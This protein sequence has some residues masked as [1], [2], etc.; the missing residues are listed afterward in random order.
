MTLLTLNSAL[1]SQLAELYNE[2]EGRYQLVAD[3]LH[4]SCTGCPDNC[5][6]SYF[7][8]H[9][10]VEWAYLW[11]GFSSLPPAKQNTI[12]ARAASYVKQ[13]EMMLLRG[14]RPN[15][16]CPLNDQ[17]LCMLYN[18]RYMICRL[19]GVPA[20]LSLPDG[21]NFNFPG[22]FRCQEIVENLPAEKNP[23]PL[24]RSDLFKRLADIE[25]TCIGRG[26]HEVPKVK[27]T[28]AH[29]LLKGPPQ[30]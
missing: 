19:H 15:I 13:S 6:D 29:M 11:Q 5:C 4:F 24:Q 3:N 28:I 26:R 21:R 27:M 25:L 23:A 14:E 10:Y 8:H 9:T 22:C 17:G 12:L 30:L 1:A 16:M 20:Q 18:H 7:L 2:M